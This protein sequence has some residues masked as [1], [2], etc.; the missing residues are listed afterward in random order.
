MPIAQDEPITLPYLIYDAPVNEKTLQ[1]RK[2]FDVDEE[3]GY[4]RF[5]HWRPVTRLGSVYKPE[6]PFYKLS[7]YDPEIYYSQKALFVCVASLGAF[8]THFMLSAVC[9]RPYWS[10]LH[11]LF[12]QIAGFSYLGFWLQDKTIK[13]AAMKNAVIVDY[14]RKHPERF[15]EIKR[16]KLREILRIYTPIR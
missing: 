2:Q 6:D 16:H 5:Y 4:P 11:V 12:G 10:Q 7:Q 13:R 8:A 9:K 14:M 3:S 15:G 1:I